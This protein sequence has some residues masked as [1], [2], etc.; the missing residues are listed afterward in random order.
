MIY[1]DAFVSGATEVRCDRLE[2]GRLVAHL[3]LSDDDVALFGTPDDLRAL[4]ERLAAAVGEAAPP[5]QQAAPEPEPKGADRGWC[6]CGQ[7]IMY[8]VH[9]DRSGRCTEQGE[10]WFH[11]EDGPC[12][13]GHAL[14]CVGSDGHHTELAVCDHCGE[15]V[16]PS[17]RSH[18][19]VWRH[20]SG[21]HV[22]RAGELGR[23]ARVRGS[24]LV[25][26]SP[27]AQAAS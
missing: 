27:T 5:A 25:P 9:A 23:L 13:P 15:A 17:H 19:L 4:A 3:R 26:V 16:E 18:G 14:R 7:P 8:G 12:V 10:G 20:A 1:V 2:G 11:T 21:Y 24:E 22:C 6:V